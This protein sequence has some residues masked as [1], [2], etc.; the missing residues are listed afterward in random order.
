MLNSGVRPKSTGRGALS[1]RNGGVREP[2]GRLG[3]IQLDR[4][5]TSSTW[6]TQALNPVVATCLWES[7]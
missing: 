5:G 1:P 6:G 3:G 2:A 4:E 7:M